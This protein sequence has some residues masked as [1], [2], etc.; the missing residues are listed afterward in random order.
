MM[1]RLRHLPRG[2]AAPRADELLDQFDLGEA[3]DRG[4]RP[5]PAACGAGS[6]WRRAWSPSRRCC[7][8]TSRPPVWTR[9]AGARCGMPSP[10]WP[11]GDTVLLTTQYLEEADQLADRIAVIDDGRVVAEGTAGELKSRI[12]TETLVLGFDSMSS[13][14]RAAALLAGAGRGNR[15][16]R[17][18]LTVRIPTDGTAGAVLRTL[19][20]LSAAGLPASSGRHARP[21]PRTR[22]SCTS[23]RPPPPR[24]PHP[25]EDSLM[26]TATLTHPVP[27]PGSRTS[28][29]GRWPT[30]GSS[31]AGRSSTAC[32]ASTRW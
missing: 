29:A 5:T 14:H 10:R 16:W 20:A 28:G 11:A 26:S 15:R 17:D 18:A 22:S 3:A 30:A 7:S 6:T 8:S 1:G 21:H 24:P 19:T 9:A 32:A 13:P 25:G 31:S 4:S 23:P 12:G 27:A 2:G